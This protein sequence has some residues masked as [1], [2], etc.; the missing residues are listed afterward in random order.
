MHIFPCVIAWFCPRALA[1]RIAEQ[2]SPVPEGKIR[3]SHMEKY[4]WT[5]FT[6]TLHRYCNL[7]TETVKNEYK[8]SRICQLSAAIFCFA[9]RQSSIVVNIIFGHRVIAESSVSAWPRVNGAPS[10]IRSTTRY[11]FAVASPAETY[12]VPSHEY[13]LSTMG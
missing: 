1:C 9:V 8:T 5:P 4:A 11:D 10:P 7:L 13:R 2:F 12:W 3:R 6:H